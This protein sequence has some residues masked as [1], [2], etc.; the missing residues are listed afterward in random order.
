MCL[1]SSVS[2]H[3]NITSLRFDTIHCDHRGR[4]K[5]HTMRGN[6]GGGNDDTGNSRAF[7]ICISIGGGRDAARIFCSLHQ[8]ISGEWNCTIVITIANTVCRVLTLCLANVEI[9]FSLRT[10]NPTKSQTRKTSCFTF[11]Y[12]ET[13]QSLPLL[14]PNW[15]QTR[16]KG[17][18][19]NRREMPS[20]ELILFSFVFPR[21]CQNWMKIQFDN[22]DFPRTPLTADGFFIALFVVSFASTT[23]LTN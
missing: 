6:G 8:S 3:C 17:S 4:A 14:I 20:R 16:N 21:K 11:G 13:S 23:H 5:L 10:A 18:G 12:D 2:L 15:I 22:A 7:L 19:K 1:A 9:S